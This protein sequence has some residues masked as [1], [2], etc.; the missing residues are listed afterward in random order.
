M[1]KEYGLPGGTMVESVTCGRRCRLLLSR[2]D[3][4]R[5]VL[6]STAAVALLGLAPAARADDAGLRSRFADL[7]AAAAKEGEIVFYSD[8]RQ[9]TAERISAFWKAN[10]P[11]VRLLITPK[12]S[13]AL[14]AQV[15]AERSAGQHR[16]DVTHMSQMYVAAIWKGKDVYEPYKISSFARYA[17]DYADPDGAFYTPEV[18][19][20][21]A[22]YNTKAFKDKSELPQSL[23]DYLDPK[24]KGKL[25]LPDPTTSGNTLTFMTTM[26][27]KGLIDW[28]Y[29][30]KLAQQDVLFVRGNPDAV[31]MIASGERMVTPM[32]SLFNLMSAKKKGQPIDYYVLKEGSVA[33][34]SAMGIMAGAPHPNAARLF[35]EALMSPEGEAVLAE[36]GAFWPADSQVKAD[37]SLPPI[38]DMHPINP[39]EPTASDQEQINAFLDKFKQVFHRH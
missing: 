21:P 36:G 27:G 1:L 4:M 6:G 2:R 19:T 28:P 7:Y 13:P 25:V 22:A 23:A 35:M 16:V 24:W 12:G 8:G 29:L 30:E 33:V 3:S 10:F 34:Q 39:P 26:M 11:D 38:A 9:D 37:P 14:I 17:P 15:E 5:V 32:L 20:L 18:Y 31:R